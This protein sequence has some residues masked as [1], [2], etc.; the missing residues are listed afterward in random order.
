MTAMSQLSDNLRRRRGLSPV[1]PSR[2]SPLWNVALIA[3]LGALLLTGCTKE[4]EKSG[5]DEIETYFDEPL[6]SLSPEGDSVHWIGGEYGDLWRMTA[7]GRKHYKLGSD[8]IYCV[9]R[10]DSTYWIGHR[11]GGLAQYRFDGNTF[12]PVAHYSIDIKGLHYSVYDIRWK[13]GRL[14]AATSQGL[15]VLNAAQHRLEKVYPRDRSNSS[16]FATPLIANLDTRRLALATDSGLA[17]LDSHSGKAQV[18][19]A[20][21]KVTW[22]ERQGDRLCYLAGDQYYEREPNGEEKTYALPDVATSFFRTGKTYCFISRTHAIL[23]DDLHHFSHLQLRRPVPM[24]SSHVVAQSVDDDFV[25]LVTDHAV[26]QVPRHLSG[27]APYPIV[28]ACQ[29]E[30]RLCFVDDHGNVFALPD[31]SRQA[32]KIFDF[33]HTNAIIDCVADNGTLYYLNNQQQIFRLTL[34]NHLWGN[35]L[36]HVPHEIFATKKKVTAMGL[37]PTKTPILY[38]GVQD[39]MMKLPLDSRQAHSV[40]SFRD[41]YVTSFYTAP[42]NQRMM[43]ATLNDGLWTDRGDGPQPVFAHQSSNPRLTAIINSYPPATLLATNDGIY[44]QGGPDTIR[45]EG[46]AALLPV[47][48]S[49]VYALL[50]RGVM[51]LKVEGLRLHK[52]GIYFRDIKFHPQA[53]LVSNGQLYL[54]SDLGVLCFKTGNEQQAEWIAMETSMITRRSL[55][56]GTAIVLG[57]LLL[58]YLFLLR[59][60]RSYRLELR[61]RQR[62]LMRRLEAVKKYRDILSEEETHE[63]RNIETE[64]HRLGTRKKRSWK[65]SNQ[66]FAAVSERI[67]RLN[68]HM[69]IYFVRLVLR[70][71]DAIRQTELFDAHQLIGDSQQV[72]TQGRPEQLGEQASRNASWLRQISAISQELSKDLD[73]LSGTLPVEGVSDDLP[74]IIDSYR[75]GL[76]IKPIGDMAPTL[77]TIRQRMEKLMS[78]EVQDRLQRFVEQRLRDI[79]AL[80]QQD[81]VTDTLIHQWSDMLPTLGSADRIAIL[82]RLQHLD[83][84]YHELFALQQLRHL[85]ARYTGEERRG[86]DTHDTVHA[87]KTAIDRFYVALFRTDPRLLGSI[88]QWSNGENQPARVLALLLADPKVKRLL[89]PGMLNVASNLNPVISR[90]VKGKLVPAEEDIRQYAER[91]PSSVADYI[92]RLTE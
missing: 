12:A 49:V 17:L 58:I 10:H 24:K 31:G 70:Q 16:P 30:G 18:I 51:K 37:L 20:G 54:G 46:T 8:R 92:I 28:A 34:G 50:E 22:V 4:K 84:R 81:K 47:N 77:I 56:E 6:A 66:C 74:T 9:V 78:K 86:D 29:D 40:A 60:R 85:I 62:D 11:N 7:R 82:R 32:G 52:E 36:S 91:H 41:K 59:L 76:A 65:V 48:D 1:S 72:L 45:V 38:I 19:H 33:I 71:I 73:Q 3:I 89:L 63:L 15:F 75:K 14:Y 64:L 53:S 87:I 5:W 67:M 83:D 42:D 88:L 27:S 43:I 21:S 2:R 35:Y 26:W 69:V 79:A 25:W 13:D 23:T 44:L 90:L 39:G 80:E 68:S 61:A 55:L 57:T